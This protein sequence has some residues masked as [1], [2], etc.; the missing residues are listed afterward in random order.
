MSLRQTHAISRRHWAMHR[1][2]RG[3]TLIELLVVMAV[4]G[5]LTMAVFPLAEMSVQR[6]REHELKRALW[7][8]RDAIDAYKNAVAAGQLPRAANGSAYPPSLQALVQGLPNAK[9]PGQTLYFLRR[10]PRDPFA[11]ETLPAEATWA[12]RSY[13]SPPDHPAPGDDVYDVAS[14]SERVGMNGVP[15]KLW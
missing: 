6:D 13:Q 3:F 12:L 1:R 5:I 10:I 14:R 4:M 11:P 7:E 15:L 8:L 9:L 2:G